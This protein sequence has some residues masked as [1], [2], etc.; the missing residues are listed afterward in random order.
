[1]MRLVYVVEVVMSRPGY[2]VEAA[3]LVTLA[4]KPV[5][6]RPGYLIES[7]MSCALARAQRKESRRQRRRELLR[8]SASSSR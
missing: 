4:L 1:M 6:L 8:D 5:L 2:I 7:M 3:M